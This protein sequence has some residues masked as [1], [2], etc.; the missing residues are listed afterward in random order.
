MLHISLGSKAKSL[1]L[2][3]GIT[4][5]V[6]QGEKKKKIPGENYFSFYTLFVVLVVIVVVYF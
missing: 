4:E 3:L 5:Q 2:N 1:K 6:F